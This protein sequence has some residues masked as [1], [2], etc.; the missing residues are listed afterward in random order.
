MVTSP[1]Y[2]IF[3]ANVYGNS[4][5]VRSD[6]NII[7]YSSDWSLVKFVALPDGFMASAYLRG[8]ELV[9]SYAGTTNEN[10]YDWF[11]GNVPAAT[12]SRLAPEIADAA[13]FYLE[14]LQMAQAQVGPNIDVS[15][16]GHSLGGGQT[17]ARSCLAPRRGA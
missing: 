12:A 4:E 17:E 11:N 1:E 7:P 10:L 6:Q 3:A 2:A 15:F 16:T 14:A 13:E 5:A 8:N 9:I